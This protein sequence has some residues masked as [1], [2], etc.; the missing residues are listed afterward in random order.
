MVTEWLWGFTVF[1]APG[2]TAGSGLSRPRKRALCYLCAFL[3]PMTEEERTHTGV[4]GQHRTERA[5]GKPL[6]ALSLWETEVQHD[7]R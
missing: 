1:I 4:V 6:M 7:R 5:D 2:A 3:L